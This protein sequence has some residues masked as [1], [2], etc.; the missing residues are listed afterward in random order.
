MGFSLSLKVDGVQVIDKL[1]KNLSDLPKDLSP[2]FKRVR[3][4][5]QDAIVKNFVEEGRGDGPWP[6]L[7]PSTIESRVRK[8]FGDGPI[9]IQTGDMVH[10][11]TEDGPDTINE[12]EAQR[13]AFGAIGIKASVFHRGKF[14][15]LPR[16][17][18]FLDEEDKRKIVYEFRV[19]VKN[20]LTRSASDFFGGKR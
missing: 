12:I 1:F 20:V 10:S 4:V 9:G 11:F 3:G 13:A 8:G 16:P 6:A 17:V 19:E 5:I 14:N 18:L 15:Q 2:V 7:R